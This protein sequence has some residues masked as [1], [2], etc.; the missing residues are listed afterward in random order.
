MNI[1]KIITSIIIF[2]NLSYSQKSDNIYVEYYFTDNSIYKKVKAVLIFNDTESI[3]KTFF[4]EQENEPEFKGNSIF[5]GG[6]IDIYQQTNKTKDTLATYNLIEDNKIL[7][8]NEK[9]P[10][11]NWKLDFNDEKKIG[12]Y[13]CKKATT[14]FRGREFTAW[15]Y[16]DIPTFFGPWKFSGLPGLIIEIHDNTK[17]FIWKCNKI[18]IPAKEN[19]VIPYKKYS[20]ISIKEY[21][22]KVKEYMDELRSRVK[23]VLP[24]G[25]EASV[26]KNPR[27]GLELVYE[28]EE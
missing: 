19:I 10:N 16:E 23:R 6:L 3:F 26:P 11:F 14:K 1:K 7:K 28:W 9:I 22:F 12:N 8:I 15:Y 5:I 18:E 2:V 25:A 13:I 4:G 21:V 27:R 17:T 20:S 24:R